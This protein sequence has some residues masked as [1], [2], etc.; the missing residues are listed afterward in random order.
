[1]ENKFPCMRGKRLPVMSD[2]FKKLLL[3]RSLFCDFISLISFLRLFGK[4]F[5]EYCH[6]G[7]NHTTA[8]DKTCNSR[9]VHL[10]SRGYEMLSHTYRAQEY[11]L[12]HTKV[13]PGTCH[14][15]MPCIL[16]WWKF[17]RNAP[18][19]LHKDSGICLIAI[20]RL[21]DHI[22]NLQNGRR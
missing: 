15:M 8:N 3:E 4:P 5:S 10:M 17:H 2:F 1:M 13:C 14:K 16:V 12:F 21:K 19:H 22:H 18:I 7:R 11:C 9:S 6:L 20:L